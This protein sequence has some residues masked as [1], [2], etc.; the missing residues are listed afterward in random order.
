MARK[1]M[2]IDESKCTAC[3]G[4]QVAC[5][6]WN[7]L[8]GWEYS[9]TANEGSYENPPRLT[10]QTWTKIK[11]TEVDKPEGFRWLF[12]K[13]GCMHCGNAACVDVCPTKALKRQADGRVTVEPDLC[14]GCGYCSQFCPFGIPKLTVAGVFTGAAKASKCT[15]CQDR[16]DNGLSP[17]C[18]KT[19]PAKSLFW[20][21]RDQMVAAGKKRVEALKTRGF[22]AANLYGEEAVG[23]LGR[24]YVLIEKPE[25]YGLPADPQYP[26]LAMTWQN[27]IQPLGKIAIGGTLLGTFVAWL[28][29][30]RNIKMEEVE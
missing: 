10:P 5:K 29:I 9:K 22:E 28:I 19:C 15:F 20:G 11:F 21:D 30:R 8:T 6:Q 4:C 17:S 1:A 7:E 26:F 16:T 27:I 13:E 3:R 14:N 12:L 24:L 25:T 2:L 18:V 23:G